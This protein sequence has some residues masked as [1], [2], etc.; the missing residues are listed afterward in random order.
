[1]E[2]VALLEKMKLEHL[3]HQLDGVCEQA[4]QRDLDYKSFL[5]QAL[6]TEYRGRFQRG[7]ETRIKIPACWCLMNSG[8]WTF[9]GALTKN[10]A[11]H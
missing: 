5:T 9:S 8:N 4:A 11:G 10:G 6:Q 2:L 1:M 3:A 7:T